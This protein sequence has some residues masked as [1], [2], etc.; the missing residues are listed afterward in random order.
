[1]EYRY[2]D[3]AYLS[4]Y[5]LDTKLFNQYDFIVEDAAPIRAIY[6]LTTNKGNKILKKISYPINEL[7][8][9]YNSLNKIR[10]GYPYV[11]NFKENIKGIPYV[12]YDGGTYVVIDVIDGRECSFENV[13]DLKNVSEA[14]AKLH[15][16]G[17]NIDCQI[18][19]RN[20]CGKMIELIK[21]RIVDMRKYNDIADL[22]INKSEFDKLYLMYSSYYIYESEKAAEY[23][24]SS[25]Y[26]DKSQN[27]CTLCHHDLAHHNIMIGNDQNIYFIDFDY[28]IIDLPYHDLCNIITKAV[29]HNLWNIDIAQTIIDG[30][31]SV[32]K[33]D[34]D[35]MKILYGYLMFPQDFYEIASA[36]YFRTRDWEEDEFFEKLKRRSEYKDMRIKFLKEFEDKWLKN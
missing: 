4:S 8:F 5:L 13:V 20:M 31:S 10:K 3:K 34:Y 22:H 9:I 17:K 1:M 7:V 29:K 26:R 11:M 23:L 27:E 21:R 24:E 6:V 32:K 33:L 28:C 30:Y 2:R 35:E 16:A 19:G 25:S 14:L 18:A 12:N 15:M 36:Y